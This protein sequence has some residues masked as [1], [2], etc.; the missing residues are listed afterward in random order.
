MN[1]E[2]LAKIIVDA[3]LGTPGVSLFVHE[4]PFECTQGLLLRNP[5]TGHAIDHYLPG[6][7][8]DQDIQAIVRSPRHQDGQNLANQVLNA[9]TITEREIRE[10]NGNLGMFI[11][12]MLPKALP[13]RYQRLDGGR[14]LEWSLNFCGNYV[15]Y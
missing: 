15:L 11:Q 1:Y 8:A 10:E 6:Y 3:G 12:L 5:L 9:L 2:L 4:M 14:E 7:F 13:I